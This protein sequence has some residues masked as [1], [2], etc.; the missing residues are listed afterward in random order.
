MFKR[1]LLWILGV[2][3]LGELLADLCGIPLDRETELDR[4]MAGRESAVVRVSGCVQNIRRTS[5]GY[6]YI[7]TNNDVEIEGQRAAARDLLVFC[8]GAEAMKVGQRWQVTGTLSPFLL[9][10]N[11]GEFNLQ[12]YYRAQRID[13]SLR[14]MTRVCVNAS[15][16]PV[17]D[18]LFRLRERM[19]EVIR[20]EA[21]TED[22]GVLLSILLG[23][24]SE[25][26][27]DMREL[28]QLGGISHILAVSGLH[29]SLFGMTLWRLL[30]RSPAPRILSAV[31]SLLTVAGYVVLTG[32]GSSAVR[33]GI[34]FGLML[35]AE[36]LGRTYDLL[37]AAALAGIF[38]LW[39]YPLLLWQS[40]FQ[41]SFLAVLAVGWLLPQLEMP[42]N[43]RASFAIQWMT[44]PV[45]AVMNGIAPLGAVLLN[46]LV[47]PLSG[48]VLGTAAVGGL[49]GALA[50]LMSGMPAAV[51]PGIVAHV[52]LMP[53][54]GILAVYRMAAS[55]AVRLPGYLWVTGMPAAWQIMLYY[56]CILVW[57]WG[58]GRYKRFPAFAGL[59]AAVLLSLC[60]L[61]R[62]PF[63]AELQITALDVGQGDSLFIRAPEGDM[64]IDAGS[65]SADSVGIRRVLPFLRSQ[66]TARLEV[67]LLT[68]ADSDHYNA[69]ADLLRDPAL[70]VGA[71]GMTQTAA[72]DPEIADILQAAEEKGIPV[73]IV[74]A[75][76]AWQL[77]NVRITCLYPTPEEERQ[78]AEDNKNETSL[79]IRLEQGSFSALFTG[80]LGEEGE[81]V[82]MAREKIAEAD[83]LKAGHHGSRYAS[84]APFL[85][86]VSPEFVIFSCGKHNRY[87]HPHPDTVARVRRVG[88]RTA[89]TAESGAV[90]ILRRRGRNYYYGYK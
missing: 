80:D 62:L 40:G 26:G 38:L 32:S 42:K 63:T 70:S 76:D 87:G 58:K 10:G 5:S 3:I 29:V 44:L 66:G 69:M 21:G 64:L 35:G 61:H 82:W 8:E 67:L 30:K 50:W 89:S 34:M 36:L 20:A 84:T 17:K 45:L 56:G 15:F 86:E 72:R 46:A 78:F 33:A 23:D 9:P 59:A 14:E 6:S 75:G 47:L 83:V 28:Y 88:A 43:I 81:K 39:Q 79:V 18:G 71:L 13:F 1:P 52:C 12:A 60:C 7:L 41:L 51:I 11:P 16:S 31:L 73:R 4:K 49:T 74:T 27:I 37:S 25:L 22:A 53:A 85:Q 2:W 57:A 90:T 19:G 68:H 24:R 77:G 65:S 48:V 55:C 54:R